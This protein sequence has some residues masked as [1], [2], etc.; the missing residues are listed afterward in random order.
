MTVHRKEVMDVATDLMNEDIARA[1][2]WGCDTTCYTTNGCDANPQ[3]FY[4][5]CAVSCMEELK[6]PA[7]FKVTPV[8]GLDSIDEQT[9][10]ALIRQSVGADQTMSMLGNNRRRRP[11]PKLSDKEKEEMAIMDEFPDKA[12]AFM[13]SKFPEDTKLRDRDGI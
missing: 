11:L 8:A 2:L 4:G 13:D 10:M 5:G 6:C 12:R 1:K 3:A 7:P 9:R